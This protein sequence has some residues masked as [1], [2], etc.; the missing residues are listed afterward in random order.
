MKMIDILTHLAKG[1]RVV[2]RYTKDGNH[3]A[4]DGKACYTKCTGAVK[5]LIAAKLAHENYTTK[6][7]QF[8]TAGRDHYAMNRKDR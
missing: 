2:H 8:T 3:W 7:L 6:E 4:A 5:A 1:G